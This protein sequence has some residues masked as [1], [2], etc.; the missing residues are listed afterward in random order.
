MKLRCVFTMWRLSSLC[1]SA[2]KCYL[3]MLNGPCCVKWRNT[4]PDYEQDLDNSYR[5]INVVNYCMHGIGIIN[6]SGAKKN[7]LQFIQVSYGYHEKVER[8]GS[9]LTITLARNIEDTVRLKPGQGRD[10]YV[11]RKPN[12]QQFSM[13]P[14]EPENVD[15]TSRLQHLNFTLKIQGWPKF[16][17]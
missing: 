2:Q 13:D 6:H 3:I 16:L 1:S 14:G 11:T 9:T 10:Q 17:E 5:H 8:R 4:Q 12:T 7:I 15:G